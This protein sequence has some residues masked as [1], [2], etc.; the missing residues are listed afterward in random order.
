M[1]DTEQNRLSARAVRYAR[2]GTNVG[3]IAARIAASRFFG[4][5]STARRMPRRSAPRSAD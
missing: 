3:V 5:G 4:L 1:A 2:V